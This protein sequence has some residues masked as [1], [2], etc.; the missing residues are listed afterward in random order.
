M[1]L[2]NWLPYLP[3][4][5]TSLQRPEAAVVKDLLSQLATAFPQAVYYGLRTIL[6]SLREVH[7]HPMENITSPLPVCE[8]FYDSNRSLHTLSW[9]P[10]K[11]ADAS[12]PLSLWGCS[13]TPGSCC[14]GG[15]EGCERGA[16]ERQDGQR[17]PAADACDAGRPGAQQRS[18]CSHC[19]H[20]GRCTVHIPRL[21]GAGRRSLRCSAKQR[22]CG[23]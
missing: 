5:Q 12:L 23:C 6:L 19:V 17:Q 18:A 1:P 22:H 20:P 10:Q 14:T 16:P 7:W 13:M 4:L 9:I 3:Q 8:S 2:N 21:R 15:R 11:T